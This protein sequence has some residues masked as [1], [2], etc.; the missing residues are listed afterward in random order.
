[1]RFERCWPLA[2]GVFRGPA[3]LAVGVSVGRNCRAVVVWCS[4]DVRAWPVEC[5][6]RSV[7]RKRE[8]PP[9]RCGV[10]PAAA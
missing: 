3:R 1:V 9:V 2:V 10:L 5:P 6:R 8:V 7:P 4:A